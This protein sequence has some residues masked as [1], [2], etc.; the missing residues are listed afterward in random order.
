[1]NE[2]ST[3]QAPDSPVTTRARPLIFLGTYIGG[4]V[5][6]TG[7]LTFV[8][9][10]PSTEDA[11]GMFFAVLLLTIVYLPWG[12]LRGIAWIAATLFGLSTDLFDTSGTEMWP[13]KPGAGLLLILSYASFVGLMIW[14]SA[15]KHQKTFRLVYLAFVILLILNIGGCL[16]DPP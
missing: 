10:G 16:V 11:A 2:T 1:M 3:P 5:V 14:G 7:L 4:A 12:L 15:T 13:D 8:S 6:L 9:G